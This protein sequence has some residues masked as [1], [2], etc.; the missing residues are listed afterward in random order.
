MRVVPDGLRV[1]LAQSGSLA[2]GGKSLDVSFPDNAVPGSQQLYLDVFPAFLS[3][4]VSGLD[5]ILAEPNGC[6]EQTTST[7]WPNVLVTRYME[8]TGQTTPEI[9][10]KAES[11]I[12]AGYQRLLTFEH[13]GGGF[14]WFGMQDPAPYL[15]VTAFGLMEF[16]DMAGVQE[17]DANMLQRTTQW[18]VGQQ[19]ADGSWP[20]DDSEFFTFVT[21]TVRNTAFVVWALASAGYTGSEVQRGLDYIDPQLAKDES[22]AYTVA[23]VANAF[24]AAAQNDPRTSDLLDRLDGMKQADGDKLHWDSGDTQTCFYG[25]GNDAAV[26]ATALAANALLTAGG[27]AASVQ[28]ALEYLVSSRDANGNFGSTQATVWSLKALLLAALKGTEGAVGDF[29]VA[30]DGQPFDS[31][32]L[33]KDQSDVMTRF[34][35]SALAT[36]GAHTV[37]LSFSGTGKVSYNLVSS[38]HIPWSDVPV[39]PAGPLSVQ[40]A[41]DRTTLVVDETVQATVTVKNLTSGSE[42][43][44]LVTVGI[45]PGFEV[46]TD[47]LAQYLSGAQLSHYELTGKQLILYLTEL[48]ANASQAFSYRLRATMPVRAVDGGATVFPYYEPDQ[49]SDTAS[50]QLVSTAD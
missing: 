4:A 14:S 44:I 7:T 15:S 10:L 6:F 27:Y 50:Q 35:M 46:L 34:D 40:I 3:Q 18:L 45:P 39:E 43:M 41:Y 21:S 49:K 42:N 22:D 36:T 29:S 31:V 2:D 26:T 48:P 17:V 23:L 16:S 24:A 8:Q 25:A 9:Q 37:G 13:D 47:D 11:L 32:K 38:H 12:S 5:S 28:G 19:Q 33:T 1:P 30:L 20:G